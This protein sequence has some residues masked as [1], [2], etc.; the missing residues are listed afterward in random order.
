M[1]T[2]KASLCAA[3]AILHSSTTGSAVRKACIAWTRPLRRPTNCIRNTRPRRRPTHIASRPEVIAAGDSA[4]PSAGT[5]CH[6][7]LAR[8]TPRGAGCRLGSRA[9]HNTRWQ[10]SA[11]ARQRGNRSGTRAS[12]Q[13]SRAGA[14]A[15]AWSRAWAG[16]RA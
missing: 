3:P 12:F 7:V 14:R 16:A 4:V 1:P 10:S 9:C 13:L 2:P 5:Y 15:G 11:G 6:T 8:C